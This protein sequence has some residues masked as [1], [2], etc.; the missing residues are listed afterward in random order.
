[1][2]AN[3][4]RYRT[5]EAYRRSIIERVSWNHECN[6]KDPLYRRYRKVAVKIEN[7]KRSVEL[8][9]EKLFKAKRSLRDLLKL[10]DQI[11]QLRRKK[12]DTKPR[13]TFKKD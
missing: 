2:P 5:D 1:M 11:K 7:K 13:K 9:T 4:E 10:K 3:K 8:Y 6:L 12:R